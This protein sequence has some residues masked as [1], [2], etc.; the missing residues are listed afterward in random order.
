M[1]HV[2]VVVPG[3]FVVAIAMFAQARQTAP[4]RTEFT[5]VETGIPEPAGRSQ[6]A[7][8]HVA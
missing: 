6:R 8:D 2:N 7:E 5:V 3:L 1:K 4:V